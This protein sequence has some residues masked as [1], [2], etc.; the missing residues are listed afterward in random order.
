M[1][2][3]NVR[4]V[5]CGT[6]KKN[7]ILRAVAESRVVAEDNVHDALHDEAVEVSLVIE[8]CGV[9]GDAVALRSGEWGVS[10]GQA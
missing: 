8:L 3:P 5:G 7:S 4:V 10:G 2:W 1:K 6:I 9:L